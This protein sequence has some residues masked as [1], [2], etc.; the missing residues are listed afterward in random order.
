[1]KTLY[2]SLLD[3]EETTKNIT[4]TVEKQY[5]L[6]KLGDLIGVNMDDYIEKW[7][8]FI[9][10]LKS[11]FQRIKEPYLTNKDI[12]IAYEENFELSD[13][14]VGKK[15]NNGVGTLLILY[16][17]NLPYDDNNYIHI[18][19]FYKHNLHNNDPIYTMKLS[20]SV[21][22]DSYDTGYNRLIKSLKKMNLYKI[23]GE[24]ADKLIKISRY[25]DWNKKSY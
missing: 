18:D 20:T 22:Q 14:F 16:G 19:K 9:D 15:S 23:T 12:I 5:F 25:N 6:Y 4:N 17:E 3:T 8:A 11:Q 13:R 1:M 7:D 10:I 2:E 21:Y 24:I